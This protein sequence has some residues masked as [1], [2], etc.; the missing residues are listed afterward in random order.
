[1]NDETTI[2]VVR[3]IVYYIRAEYQKMKDD[4]T[5]NYFKVPK[6][7]VTLLQDAQGNF[8]RGVSMCSDLDIFNKK[9]GRAM[10]YNRALAG[11]KAQKSIGPINRTDVYV[12][13]GMD[14]KIEYQPTLTQFEKGLLKGPKED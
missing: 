9:Q 1:M 14:Y 8:A 7:T 3:T 6:S 4:G 13:E 10:A 12:E 11:L 5:I 2:E